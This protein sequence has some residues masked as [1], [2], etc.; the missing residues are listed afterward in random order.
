MAVY[1]IPLSV[2]GDADSGSV[3]GKARALGRMLRNGLPVPDGLCVTDAGL[4][5]LRSRRL[6][7]ELTEALHGLTSPTVAVRSSAGAEDSSKHSYAGIFKSFLNVVNRPGEVIAA[8]DAVRQSASSKQVEA[9]EKAVHSSN[10]SMA[11]VVQEMITA[12]WSGV[13]FTSDPVTGQDRSLVEATKTE[14]P[15]MAEYA[16]IDRSGAI[17]RGSASRGFAQLDAII[18]GLM[19]VARHCE[20]IFG[21]PQ[22]IEWV[23]DGSE[24]WVLQS[25]AVTR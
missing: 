15:A 1:V 18:G 6:A 23:W 10:A 8:L 22:D 21:G 14:D 17:V 4:A 12:R 2:A 20:K 5:D 16:A 25:R 3:G 9:Y 24:V 19:T 13:M 7:A 11:A